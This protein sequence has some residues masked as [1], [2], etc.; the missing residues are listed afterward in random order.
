MLEEELKAVQWWNGLAVSELMKTLPQ[1]VEV[2][3]LF[4]GSSC[5]VIELNN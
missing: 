4:A 5:I 2:I 1:L 3:K